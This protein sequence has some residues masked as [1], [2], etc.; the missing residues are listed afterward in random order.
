MILSVG[1]KAI[2]SPHILNIDTSLSL[3]PTATQSIGES[4][5]LLINSFRATPLSLSSTLAM[6]FPVK[7]PLSSISIAFARIFSIPTFAPTIFAR[8]SIPDVK[9]AV[10]ILL[11]FNILTVSSP[12]FNRGADERISSITEI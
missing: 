10:S 8:I 2:P 1:L 11:F 12:P 7:Y 9:I 6:E 5:I 4:P 3:F